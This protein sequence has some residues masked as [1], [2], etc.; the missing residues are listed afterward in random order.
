[1]T[2]FCTFNDC[3]C[4]YINTQTQ[5]RAHTQTRV[6]AH[7]H[8]RTRTY[9]HTHRVGFDP[10]LLCMRQITLVT[11]V[12]NKPSLLHGQYQQCLMHMVSTHLTPSGRK[13]SK[14]TRHCVKHNLNEMVSLPFLLFWQTLSHLHEAGYPE[15]LWQSLQSPATQK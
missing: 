4:T 7:T 15:P 1:M 11:R 10:K 13:K 9:T 3:I 2:S 14:N 5:M 6:R 8:T 12:D